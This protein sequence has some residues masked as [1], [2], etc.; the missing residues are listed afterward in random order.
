MARAANHLFGVEDD[1]EQEKVCQRVVVKPMEMFVNNDNRFGEN[2]LGERGYPILE[3]PIGSG[4][5]GARA[6]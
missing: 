3:M 1:G 6:A 5:L 4:L 2:W